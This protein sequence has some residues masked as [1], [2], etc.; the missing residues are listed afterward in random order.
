MAIVLDFGIKPVVSILRRPIFLRYLCQIG[1]F[2]LLLLALFDYLIP[3]CLFGYVACRGFVHAI[4]V[5]KKKKK[6][7]KISE[8]NTTEI[9]SR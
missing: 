6:K 8:E 5:K 1:A 7:K 4:V 9:Q 3:S 2:V